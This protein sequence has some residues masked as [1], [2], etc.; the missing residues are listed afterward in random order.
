MRIDANTLVTRFVGRAVMIR[1]NLKLIL[2][3]SSVLGI[4]YI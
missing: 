3:P 2:A 4:G 1:L